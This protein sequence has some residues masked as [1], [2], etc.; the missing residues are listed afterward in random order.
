MIVHKSYDELISLENIFS[1]WREFQKGKKKKRDVMEFERHLEDN[2]FKLHDELSSGHYRHGPYSAF[3]I[4]DPKHRVISKALVKDRLIHHVVFNELYRIFDPTFI[5]HSYSSRLG[6]G[7]HIAVRNT[8]KHLRK[9]SC[10]Y[11][12][13]AYILKCDI[14]KFFWSVDHQK[15][16]AIIQNKIKDEKVLRLTNEIIRS[17]PPVD[18]IPERERELNA[19]RV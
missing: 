5:F 3:H 17:F 14:K 15:L 4:H 18:K 11:T 13:T 2:I 9:V 7:T 10:N 12:R 6:K 8:A 16:L 1:C 19:F